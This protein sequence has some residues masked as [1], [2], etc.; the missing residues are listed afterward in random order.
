[1]KKKSYFLEKK[2]S[3]FFL[4]LFHAHD[5]QHLEAIMRRRAAAEIT[6]LH[7]CG[8]DNDAH[9]KAS[10][11]VTTHNSQSYFGS[12]SSAPAQKLLLCR[13]MLQ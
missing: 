4:W 12:V 7:V 3:L 10:L 8:G 9:H 6:A 5:C 2:T 13:V 1:M 11:V